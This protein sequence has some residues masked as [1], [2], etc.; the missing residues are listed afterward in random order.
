MRRPHLYD[1]KDVARSREFLNGEFNSPACAKPTKKVERAAA[2]L[3]RLTRH[4]SERRLAIL[5]MTGRQRVRRRPAFTTSTTASRTFSAGPRQF[6]S[7]GRARR[8]TWDHRMPMTS[9]RFRWDENEVSLGV[10]QDGYGKSVVLLPALSSISTRGEMAPLLQKLS[11][12][13]MVMSVDCRV[14][15]QLLSFDTAS[16]E[17]GRIVRCFCYPFRFEA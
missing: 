9:I 1:G 7:A 6:G 15:H 13:S 11:A 16:V 10:S 17:S 14:R 12:D 5:S 3:G 8:L 2:E 4:A